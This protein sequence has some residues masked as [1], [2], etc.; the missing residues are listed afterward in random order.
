MTARLCLRLTWNQGPASCPNT[1]PQPPSALKKP[2]Q[3]Q[4]PIGEMFVLRLF[5]VWCSGHQREATEWD[6]TAH[7]LIPKWQHPQTNCP[8]EA[9][10]RRWRR[11]WRTEVGA[12]SQ[13]TSSLASIFLR[14]ADLLP[15]I[16]VPPFT[17][18]RTKKSSSQLPL[19]FPKPSYSS[20]HS[21]PPFPLPLQGKVPIYQIKG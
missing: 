16:P 20:I 3:S 15:F 12:L 5:T 10:R 1:E 13:P 4:L 21:S 18:T 7:Y 6:N 14:P 11:E 8:C 17:W 19:L 9:D 2:L